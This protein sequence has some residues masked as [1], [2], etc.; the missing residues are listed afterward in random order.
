MQQ[1]TLNLNNNS[2]QIL[3]K[4]PN[5]TMILC[6]YPYVVEYSNHVLLQRMD[7]IY[8]T[9]GNVSNLLN[10]VCFLL[11]EIEDLLI[12]SIKVDEYVV[13]FDKVL[14]IAFVI[15]VEVNKITIVTVYDEKN[16]TGKDSFRLSK[17]EK[18]VEIYK[19]E[20]LFFIFD[21]YQKRKIPDLDL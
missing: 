21:G 12:N 20:I 9:I 17:G 18:V 13:I 3:E 8:K 7:R 4:M 11:F 16:K 15:K 5:E 14:D 1:K 6:G 2:I 19:D 10:R